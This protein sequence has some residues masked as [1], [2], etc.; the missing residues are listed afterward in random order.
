M[1]YNCYIKVKK[2]LR[3]IQ[4]KKD[5]EAWKKL[6]KHISYIQNTYYP[7]LDNLSLSIPILPQEIQLEINKAK[8][9]I[10][11]IREKK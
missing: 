8:Q 2:K 5:I 10:A 11:Y 3:Y 1:Y 9:K 6:E 4:K 7:N